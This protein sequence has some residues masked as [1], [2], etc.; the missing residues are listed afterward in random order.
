M[1]PGALSAAFRCCFR[2][3]LRQGIFA[4]GW[5][6][7]VASI[8]RASAAAVV[9]WDQ[10][11]AFFLLF[12]GAALYVGYGW[13]CIRATKD[14]RAVLGWSPQIREASTMAI[15]LSVA[16]I[17]VDGATLLY[18]ATWSGVHDKSD[19]ILVYIPLQQSLLL[20]MEA[21]MTYILWS[22]YARLSEYKP[23]IPEQE[24]I[25]PPATS[26]AYPPSAFAP[27]PH[28]M[29][30]DTKP[31]SNGDGAEDSTGLYSKGS[32]PKLIDHKD[33]IFLKQTTGMETYSGD[34]GGIE[35]MSVAPHHT[36]TGVT[37]F[38][39]EDVVPDRNLSKNSSTS[40]ASAS[41]EMLP[42]SHTPMGSVGSEHISVEVCE[43]I[44]EADSDKPEL[45]TEPEP[46]VEVLVERIQAEIVENAEEEEK[47]VV[48]VTKAE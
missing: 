14:Y 13:A 5:A 11:N 8:F 17:V 6:L 24:N 43:R 9:I 15:G 3:D 4:Y 26:A 34:L 25:P 31:I 27:N 46:E 33:V 30:P 32:T 36:H 35:M 23:V 44:S 48:D 40:S 10:G 41:V 45:K 22:Y 47:T 2:W 28:V 7:I 42:V 38:E 18:L 16:T 12:V 39:T 20:L 19:A 21:Y 29:K 37:I 1:N